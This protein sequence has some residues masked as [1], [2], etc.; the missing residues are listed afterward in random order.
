MSKNQFAYLWNRS[1]SIEDVV[2][3]TGMKAASAYTK[4]YNLRREGV[5]LK[6][7]VRARKPAKA[8]LAALA[9][10]PVEQERALTFQ[11]HYAKAMEHMRAAQHAL[12]SQIAGMSK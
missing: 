4:A 8:R 7:F 5:G 12:Q 1:S 2:K 11:E 9:P 10:A 3:K 6:Y